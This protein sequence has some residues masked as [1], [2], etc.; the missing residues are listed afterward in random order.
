MIKGVEGKVSYFYKDLLTTKEK[1]RARNLVRMG[2]YESAITSYR[3]LYFSSYKTGAYA[4][5]KIV[6]ITTNRLFQNRINITI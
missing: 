4:Y 1:N 2:L 5:R 6:E 3:R